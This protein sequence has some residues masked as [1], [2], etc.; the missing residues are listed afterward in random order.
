MAN[1]RSVAADITNPEVIRV[2]S[3]MDPRGGSAPFTAAEKRLAYRASIVRSGPPEPVA[4]VIGRVVESRHGG[5][6]PIRIYNPSPESP[7]HPPTL[8]YLHGGGF[9]SGDLDTHD[10]VCRTLANR[11]PMVVVAVQYRLAPE[12]P[13]PA[14]LEDCADVLQWLSTEAGSVGGDPYRIYVAGDSAGGNLAASLAVLAR[15]EFG[16]PLKAQVL[17]Y[18]MLDATM[19][20]ST[21]VENAFI[22][23]FTLVDCVYAWQQYLGRNSYRRHIYVSPVLGANLPGLPPA[24]VITAGYDILAG[25]GQAYADRLKSAGIPVEH[26]HYP[27][28]VHGFFQWGGQV[29]AARSAMDRVVRYLQGVEFAGGSV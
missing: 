20:F 21:M 16:F 2:L 9:L 10:P 25:E 14:G 28:M 27:D 5:K 22:P 6:I 29:A 26:E 8:L 12:H 7:E 18:P 13:F 3:E 15:D 23:P 11:V 17:I 1:L 19:S 4:S 24:L